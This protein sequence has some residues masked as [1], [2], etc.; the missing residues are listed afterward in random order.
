[1]VC[2]NPELQSEPRHLLDDADPRLTLAR[3]LR[4]LRTEQSDLTQSQL[5]SALGGSRRLSTASISSWESLK[6]PKIPPTSRLRAYAALF[7]VDRSF[8]HGEPRLLQSA[9][10]TPEERE[11]VGELEREL[12]ALRVAALGSGDVAPPPGRPD[13]VAIAR[14]DLVTESLATGPW[15]FEDGNAITIVA[16]QWPPEQ[17]RQIPYTDI[18]DPDYTELLTFA[19]LDAL[20]ELYGHLR[21]ANPASQIDFRA[22]DKMGPNDYSAHLVSLGGPDWN[23]VTGVLLGALGLPVQVTANW[24]DSDDVYFE[25]GGPESASR[26]APRLETRDGRKALNEDVGLFARGPNPYNDRRLVT[27]C[28]GMYAR[29]TYGVVRALTDPRFRDR[30]SLYL[31][32]RFAHAD[33]FC[34]LSRVSVVN[35]TTTTPNWSQGNFRLFEWP[36]AADAR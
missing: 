8:E 24:A 2:A 20:V 22:A 10:M 14:L 1:M 7:A 17:L 13:E 33:T 15:H 16:S 5:A 32:S 34:L 31:D 30:N 29:G 11:T 18:A 26:H 28:C 36:G 21:A 6:D 35:D 25:V 19:D 23:R 3:R 12:L 4:A 9:Q 27:I